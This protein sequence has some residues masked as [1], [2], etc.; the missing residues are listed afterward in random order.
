MRLAD[1]CFAA[2]MLDGGRRHFGQSWPVPPAPR[3]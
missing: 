1:W 3:M 2:E